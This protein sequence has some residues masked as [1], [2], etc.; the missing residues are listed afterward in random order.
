MD[1][2]GDL[3]IGNLMAIGF[4]GIGH[5]SF[6]IHEI[7]SDIFPEKVSRF[8]CKDVVNTPEE[9]SP[10][11]LYLSSSSLYGTNGGSC[12]KITGFPITAPGY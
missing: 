5:S 6:D 7:L 9:C 3:G 11:L 10:T 8:V 2:I 12:I 4:M 1:R